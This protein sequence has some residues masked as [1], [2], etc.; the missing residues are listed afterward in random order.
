[1]P[2]AAVS[3]FVEGLEPVKRSRNAGPLQVA[4]PQ[5]DAVCEVQ[6]AGEI[7]RETGLD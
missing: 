4:I 7:D 5:R 2:H 3:A 6:R 1:V